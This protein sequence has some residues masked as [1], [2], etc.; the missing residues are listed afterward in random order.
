MNDIS[1][2]IVIIATY[3]RKDRLLKAVLSI[4]EQSSSNWQ[5]V[6]VD[7]GSKDG[8][9]EY[10]ESLSDPRISTH[11]FNTNAGVNKA[12]NK[13][14]DIIQE[15]NITGYI[16]LLD[17]DDIFHTRCFEEL[18]SIIQEKKKPN[19]KWFTANCIRVDGSKISKV[20]SYGSASYIF[21]YMYGK[22]IRGDL[23]HFINTNIIGDIRFT[24]RFKNSEEWFFFS[25]IAKKNDLFTINYTAKIVNTL[26]TGLLLSKVNKD[27]KIEVLKYKLDTFQSFLPEKYTSLQTISLSNE[28]AKF[29]QKEEARKLLKSM[30]LKNKIRYKYFLA[31]IRSQ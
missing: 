25:Q 18:S 28:L 12:R 2:I 13:A 7:D 17:D 8:T 5:L 1:P 10:L 16:T 27:K 14:I 22:K 6:I 24:T 31:Y 29:G 15:K 30:S 21:D 26:P 9:K 11:S 23:S 20:Q 19:L 3:D 4:T